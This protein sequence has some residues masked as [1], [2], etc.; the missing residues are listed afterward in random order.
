MI[1]SEIPVSHGW[2]WTQFVH[3]SGDMCFRVEVFAEGDK[4][5][6]TPAGL[7]RPC[8]VSAPKEVTM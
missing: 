5:D 8:T 3:L 4:D 6:N 2:D 1:G 7:N